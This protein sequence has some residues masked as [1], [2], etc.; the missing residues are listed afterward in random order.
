MVILVN[1][2]ESWTITNSHIKNKQINKIQKHVYHVNWCNHVN[3]NNISYEGD[4]KL[5]MVM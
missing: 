2:N 3:I 4:D 5:I 1:K